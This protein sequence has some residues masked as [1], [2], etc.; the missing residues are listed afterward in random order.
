V[1][2]ASRMPIHYTPPGPPSRGGAHNP[3]SLLTCTFTPYF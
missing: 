1:N 3:Q 2:S